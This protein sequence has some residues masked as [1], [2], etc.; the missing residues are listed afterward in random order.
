MVV[1][2]VKLLQ[3]SR[4]RNFFTSQP[5]ENNQTKNSLLVQKKAPLQKRAR[6][7]KLLNLSNR[8]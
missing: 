4:R 5:K 2:Q 3:D 6:N 1:F 8:K 7:E